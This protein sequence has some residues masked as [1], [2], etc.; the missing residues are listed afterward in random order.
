MGFGI[1]KK[2]S[3]KQAFHISKND[4]IGIAFGSGGARGWSHIGAILALNKLGIEPAVVTGTSIGAVAAAVCACDSVDKVIDFSKKLTPLEAALLLGEFRIPHKGGFLSGSHAMKIVSKFVPNINIESLGMRYG[5]VATDVY[6]EEAIEL[7]SGSLKDAIR[8][9]ISIPGV[10]TPH[11]IGS[12][13]LV[14]GGILNPIPIDLARK[15]GA[16]KVIAINVTPIKC[17]KIEK[18]SSNSPGIIDI[19]SRTW[20]LV[21]R[22]AVDDSLRKQQPDLLIEPLNKNYSTLD[23]SKSQEMIASGYEACIKQ[24]SVCL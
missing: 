11:K 10:F 19:M 13:Y 1:V 24:L 9:S 7:T 17:E 22:V 6:T 21:E 5:A 3:N 18:P 14:D 2:E 8:A 12:R 16:T 23:F 20:R 4:V 15:L